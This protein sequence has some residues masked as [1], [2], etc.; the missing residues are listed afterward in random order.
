MADFLATAKV[1]LSEKRD[2]I[3]QEPL[4]TEESSE[5]NKLMETLFG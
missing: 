4:S 5:V 3:N 1:Y 2:D